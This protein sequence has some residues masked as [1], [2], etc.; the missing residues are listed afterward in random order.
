MS[1]L[2]MSFNYSLAPTKILKEDVI[3]STVAYKMHCI[4]F[5]LKKKK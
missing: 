3:S 2:E 1:L 5:R 4:Q